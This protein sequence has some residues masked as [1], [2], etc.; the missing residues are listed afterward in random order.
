MLALSA[1]GKFLSFP[2]SVSEAA[3]HSDAGFLSQKFDVR[4]RQQ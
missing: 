2:F 4:L 3:I 1:V